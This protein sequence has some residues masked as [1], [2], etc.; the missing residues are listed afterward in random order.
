[1][2]SEKLLALATDDKGKE[3]EAR[4]YIGMDISLPTHSKAAL[5]YLLWMKENGDHDFFEY[6]L[7]TEEINR[8]QGST[9]LQ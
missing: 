5:P 1:L 4:T 9:R 8:I 2:T 7:A 3:A 6:A